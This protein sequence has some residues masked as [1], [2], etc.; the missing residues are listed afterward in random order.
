MA[1]ASSITQRSSSASGTHR[2]SAGE[3]DRQVG[4]LNV[5]TAPEFTTSEHRLVRAATPGP[6]RHGYETTRRPLTPSETASAVGSC[7]PMPGRSRMT[8]PVSP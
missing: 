4:A 5:P 8:G 1:C 6:R 3:V 2:G 7:V